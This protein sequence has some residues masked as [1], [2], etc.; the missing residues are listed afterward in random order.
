MKVSWAP[1]KIALLIVG[2]IF[3]STLCHADHAMPLHY[4]QRQDDP[5]PP[6]V[7]FSNNF[8]LGLTLYRSHGTLGQV[9]DGAQNPT[10]DIYLYL[11]D[12]SKDLHYQNTVFFKIQNSA[13]QTQKVIKKYTDDRFLY[14]LQ[15]A[16]P[17]GQTHSLNVTIEDDKSIVFEVPLE[18]PGLPQTSLVNS[19]SISI[20]T[21]G[22]IVGISI[23]PL[24]LFVAALISRRRNRRCNFDTTI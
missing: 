4:V 7:Y 24:A 3:M 5:T 15:L 11:Y 21:V 16:L 22:V 20:T 9:R 17:A 1:N 2:A 13:G 6:A 12:L 18:V 8:E 14:I 23:I 10:I 19:N